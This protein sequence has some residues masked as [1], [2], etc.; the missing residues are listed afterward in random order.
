MADSKFSIALE[1]RE[2]LKHKN[3]KV[4]REG[5][6]PAVIYGPNRESTNV[7]VS[8]QDA[9]DLIRSITSSSVIKAM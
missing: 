2:S 9:L 4:R 5:K 8:N 3:R 7:Q 6:V 1:K